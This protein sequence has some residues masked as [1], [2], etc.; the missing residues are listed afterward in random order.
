MS[1]T[2]NKKKAQ[3]LGMPLGTATN[4]LRKKLLFKFISQLKL[5]TCFRCKL[6][7]DA[8]HELSVDHKDAWL[9]SDNPATR[10][11]DLDNIAFSHH[12][13]NSGAGR[14]PRKKYFTAEEKKLGTL[15]VNARYK[16]QHYTPKAR[17]DR[18]LKEG[19]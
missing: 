16:R 18:Y 10:F 1:I 7:I 2:S 17:R 4:K 8:D 13:C 14:R 15:A 3:Q 9:D 5:N 6:V 12:R 11:F 19:R